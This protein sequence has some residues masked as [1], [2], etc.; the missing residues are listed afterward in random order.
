[1]AKT[2]NVTKAQ[3][4]DASK[5]AGPMRKAIDKALKAASKKK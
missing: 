5:K 4:K 2:R 1:M 3:V